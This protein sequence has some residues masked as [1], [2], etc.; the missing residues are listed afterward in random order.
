MRLGDDRDKCAGFEG[1]LRILLPI[2]PIS[3][4]LGTN[5]QHKKRRRLCASFQ[6]ENRESFGIYQST[7]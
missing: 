3:F 1:L 2:L 6:K 4:P 5:T 7:L